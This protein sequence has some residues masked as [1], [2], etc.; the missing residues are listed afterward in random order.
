M[1]MFVCLS[2]TLTPEQVEDTKAIG[3]TEILLVSPELGKMASS[4]DPRASVTEVKQIG[5]QIAESA[6]YNDC[7]IFL[8]QGEPGLMMH[9][10]LFAKKFGLH[11][12]TS[13]TERA[14]VEEAIVNPD[15][16][17]SVIKKSIFKHVQFRDLF[18]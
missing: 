9:S 3:V 13:T 16:T 15:G 5:F 4:I 7:E 11:C 17:T 12:V 18:C 14:S 8:C 10:N 2:H 6:F 1:K